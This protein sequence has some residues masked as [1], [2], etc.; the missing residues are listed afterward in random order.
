MSTTRVWC[1]LFIGLLSLDVNG[2]TVLGKLQC[3]PGQ[4]INIRMEVKSTVTQQVMGKAISF[5]ADGFALNSYHVLDTTGGRATMEYSGQIIKFKFD[6][7]G[8]R[9]DFNSADSLDMKGRYGASMKNLLSKKYKLTIDEFGIVLIALPDRIDP[10]K[11]DDRLAI[12]LNMIEVIPNMAYPPAKGEASFFKVLPGKEVAIG[13]SWSDSV[14]TLNGR[15]KSIYTLT[16]VSDSTITVEVKTTT[17]TA[18]K[19][20][21]MGGE[22]I[23]TLNKISTGQVILD[24]QSGLIKEKKIV[25]ESSGTMEAMG[26]STPVTSKTYL[27]IYVNPG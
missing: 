2:Q 19:A 5:E 24:R 6:G 9:Q 13:E 7:M 12:V 14:V 17:I 3:S 8:Q 27:S 4:N 23:T 16:A 22:S 20:M 18:E 1:F 26:G 11:T 15:A 25:T 21:V 10:V